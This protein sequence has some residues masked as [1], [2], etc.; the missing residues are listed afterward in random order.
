MGR[1]HHL[2]TLKVRAFARAGEERLAG[3]EGDVDEAGLALQELLEALWKVG[4][5]R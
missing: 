1:P 3:P 4:S 2:R 5:A